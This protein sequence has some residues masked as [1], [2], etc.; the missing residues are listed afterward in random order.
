MAE[1]IVPPAAEVAAET[2]PHL[3]RI[4]TQGHLKNYVAFA[5]KFLQENPPRPL[6]M[7]TLPPTPTP[8]SAEPLA[9]SSTFKPKPSKARSNTTHLI[10]KLIST[11]EIVK[12]EYLALLALDREAQRLR[13]REV[14][15][16]KGKEVEKDVSMEDD[17]EEERGE[18]EEGMR[19]LWQYNETGCL[20]DLEEDTSAEEGGGER[21]SVRE[22]ELALERLKEVLSGKVGPKMVHTPYFK[23]TLSTIPLPEMA[24]R[25]GITSQHIFT[26]SRPNRT[27]SQARR[28]GKAL[29]KAAVEGEGEGAPVLDDVAAGGSAVA[30]T[31]TTSAPAPAA[32]VEVVA[33]ESSTVVGGGGAKKGGKKGRGKRVVS[34]AGAG[35]VGE[36][37]VEMESP[38]KKRKV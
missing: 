18:E 38:A 25:K 4:S 22:A 23:V 26:P 24:K 11:V 36:G 35:G 15:K 17:D 12:R 20:E 7:H 21:D 9:S 32:P 1:P 33:V 34:A 14:A 29:A 13:L 8:T 37:D 30:S 6:T 16:G 27:K 3:M 5:L 10:P 31:S 28:K 2:S 19:G